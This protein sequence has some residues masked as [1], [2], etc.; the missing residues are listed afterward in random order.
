LE[1]VVDLFALAASLSSQGSEKAEYA[2]EAGYAFQA[3]SRPLKEKVAAVK[4]YAKEAL[5]DSADYPGGHGLSGDAL[6]FETRALLDL[7]DRLALLQAAEKHLDKGLQLCKTAVLAPEQ[8]E[9]LTALLL[10]SRSMARMEYANY[11][12]DKAAK[13]KYLYLAKADI[14][15][16][17]KP[18]QP[19]R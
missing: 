14:E 6:I 19:D 1:L 17:L 13:K 10:R 18:G 15:S 7:G 12:P 8:R 2:S 9:R 4:K 16:V 11:V 5:G 3:L